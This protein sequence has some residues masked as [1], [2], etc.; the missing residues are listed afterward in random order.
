MA[1]VFVTHF[2]DQ[3]YEVCDRMTVLRNG[4]LRRRVATP[5]LPQVELVG[6]DDRQ[7]ARRRWSA[8]RSARCKPRSTSAPP[9]VA[10]RR[11]SGRKGAIAPFDLAI[12]EGEVVGL[13][14]LLG[15]GRTELAR[16]FFGADHADE[17]R[18]AI[19]GA[20]Q[21]TRA[22]RWT[23]TSRSAPRT[24]GPRGWSWS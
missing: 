20:G 4:R 12:H 19:D 2:L 15:S 9:P 21:R 18:L 17:G 14:G 1:I 8:S 3:V 11:A 24:A 22:P 7:G 16:L 23:T 10:A 6:Q 5:R 13:A